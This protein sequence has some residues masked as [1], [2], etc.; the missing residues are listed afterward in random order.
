MRQL[1]QENG[2][3]ITFSLNL[4]GLDRPGMRSIDLLPSV[5]IGGLAHA[6]ALN[7]SCAGNRVKAAMAYMGASVVKGMKLTVITADHQHAHGKS[8]AFQ[9]QCTSRLLQFSRAAH[10]DCDLAIAETPA[11]RV[12][13]LGGGRQAENALEETAVQ[14][15][16]GHS[17]SIFSRAK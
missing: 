14:E 7:R 4:E 8:G 2:Q 13:R 9:S 10:V 3:S 12:E 6:A 11:L 1:S 5:G 17:A 16:D 15:F